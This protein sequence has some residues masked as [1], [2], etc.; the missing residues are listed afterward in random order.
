MY[1]NVGRDRDWTIV[2]QVLISICEILIPLLHNKDIS[3]LE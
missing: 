1:N 2:V 3:V